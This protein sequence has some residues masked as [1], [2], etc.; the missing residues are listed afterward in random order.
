[1]TTRCSICLEEGKVLYIM[2]CF[3]CFKTHE[4]HCQTHH[5]V[6]RPC[7]TQYLQIDRPPE[8]RSKEVRCLVCE[9]TV[10]PKSFHAEDPLF[11]ESCLVCGHIL[12]K[13]EYGGGCPSCSSHYEWCSHCEEWIPTPERV[14]HLMRHIR[15]SEKRVELLKD[16]CLREQMYRKHLLQECRFVYQ[17]MFHESV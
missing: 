1:M 14:D 6:C 16:L 5:K 13:D 17:T 11:L 4:P 8:E 9:A 2:S 7:G 15:E 10:S 12:S 3:P